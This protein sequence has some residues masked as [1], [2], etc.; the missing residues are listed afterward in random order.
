R[1]RGYA[2]DNEEIEEGVRCVGCVV[3][4]FSGQPVAAISVS[5]PAFRVTKEKVK[6][7]SGPVIAA[8]RALSAELGF[9]EQPVV[10][11]GSNGIKAT[12]GA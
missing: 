2:V 7:L 4:N 11:A 1:E 8:A 3:R 10:V 12:I 5:G 9:K 6:G